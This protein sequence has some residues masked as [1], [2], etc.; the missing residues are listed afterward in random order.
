MSAAADAYKCN[1]CAYST[2]QHSN[3]LRHKRIHTGERPFECPVA[4]CGK[5]FSVK[6]N[7]T[8]HERLHSD[9]RPF[10]C[11]SCDKT[12][13]L[14]HHLTKHVMSHT[15]ERPHKCAECSFAATTAGDLKVHM[16]K[17][18]DDRPFACEECEY[19]CKHKSSLVT[20][21]HTHSG[22]KP[23][24][25]SRCNHAVRTQGRLSEHMR[26]HTGERPYKCAD[27]DFASATLQN[28]R[29][30]LHKV[31]GG[32]PRCEHDTPAIYCPQCG[33]SQ[34]CE[35]R[36]TK[37]V[38][39]K[40]EGSRVCRSEWCGTIAG[41]NHNGYCLQCTVHLFPD[42][43]VSRNYK[44]KE[45]AVVKF[46]TDAYPDVTWI[47]DKRIGDGCSLRRPDMCADF[48]THVIM[49]EVDEDRHHGYDPMCTN[50]RTMELSRDVG[51][52]PMVIIRFNPD[53]YRDADGVKV[54]SCWSTTKETGLHRVPDRQ[55]THWRNR[56]EVLK[57]TITRWIVN[58]PTR[59]VV[60]TGLF[61]DGEMPSTLTS[62]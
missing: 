55:Q 12:F 4:G 23:F 53:S 29:T 60:I 33:G 26:T 6:C 21:M 48:G 49:V 61:Y 47:N 15:G 3:L 24:K 41:D 14:K 43:P 16:R 34:Y 52:R 38:C 40:C 28:L 22:D 37:S 62:E 32:G 35:H 20:H 19:K 42:R 7:L 10:A 5:S 18:N 13:K 39:D 36:V 45:Y 8:T 17:H 51:H 46:V 9:E 2:H 50:R 44:T 54:P 27:C 59:I 31:H 58:R 11:T 56:L 1:E 25:C 57:E 30:H